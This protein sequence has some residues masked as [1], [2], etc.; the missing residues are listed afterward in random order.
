MAKNPRNQYL[1]RRDFMKLGAG[2]AALGAA[3][4]VTVLEPQTLA[5]SAR[6][7]PPSDTVRFGIIG[8]G[9]RGFELLQATR[10]V[11]G[12]ECVAAA[13]LYD[14]RHLVAKEA[15]GGKDIATTRD[16]RQ[17]LDR[18][19][20]DAV[21]IATMDHWHRELVED[22]CAAGKDV[23]CEKPMS[24]NVADGFAM[25]EAAQ[26][27]KR[28]VTVGSQRVSSILYAKAA[29]IYKSG[30]LGIV[31]TIFG[32]WDRNGDSGAWV[33][34][35]PPDASDKTI[36]WSTFLGSKPKRSYDP[37]LFFRWRCYKDFG[38]GLAGDLFVHI[39]SGIQRVTGVNAIPSR[40]LSTGG[41]YYFKDGREFPDLL[42]T[43]YDYPSFQVV[44]RCNHN[45]DDVGEFFGFYGKEG[46]LEIRG[47]RLI[48]RPQDTRPQPE[49]YSIWGWP[50]KMRSEYFA[51]WGKKHP[52]PD[53]LKW[54]T[55]SAEEIY[56]T[57]SGYN[58]TADHLA[59]WFDSIRTRKPATEDEVFGNNTSVACH[60]A[61]TSYFAGTAARWDAAAKTIKT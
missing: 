48:F 59:N 12:V 39:L 38:A 9:V 52:Q 49:G 53:A 58:D 30:K 2:A 8:T 1:S 25:V 42:W 29:E 14:S 20:L 13:D 21:I 41:L 36:D 56:T 35:I 27:H 11:S 43:M 45:N 44:T 33:Y 5:A 3:V 40:A 17:V 4:K 22:A 24:H 28:M 46:T 23:Y 55:D 61:N 31:S 18:K 51:E 6:P 50:A 32:A 7:V 19:D 34:P 16:Y 57:P 10:R 37:V 15:L 26:K 60:M 54:K 47:N